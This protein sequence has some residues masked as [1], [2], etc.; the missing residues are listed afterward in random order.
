[1]GFRRWGF[2]RVAAWVPLLSWVGMIFYLSSQSR[3]PGA[4]SV[5]W[6]PTSY[7]DIV[8]HFCLYF[9]LGVFLFIAVKSVGRHKPNPF[10]VLALAAAS[11]LIGAADEIYQSFVPGRVSS[12]ADWLADS[13]GGTSAIALLSWA[14]PLTKLKMARQG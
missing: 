9:M 2:W 6:I 13:A 5:N 8:I 4:E 11:V 14:W 10:Q 1:L 7:E 12:I 3:P